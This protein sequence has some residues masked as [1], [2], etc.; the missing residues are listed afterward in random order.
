MLCQLPFAI[1]QPTLACLRL[2]TESAARGS[3][4]Q[5]DNIQ[6]RSA[7]MLEDRYWIHR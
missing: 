6:F 3:T 7:H 5:Y 2:L 1:L 4:I